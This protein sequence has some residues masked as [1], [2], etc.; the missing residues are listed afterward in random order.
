MASAKRFVNQVV[1]VGILDRIDGTVAV[2][3]DFDVMSTRRVTLQEDDDDYTGRFQ[4]ADRSLL[5]ETKESMRHLIE[6]AKCAHVHARV[7]K[8][9]I[10]R[11]LSQRVTVEGHTARRGALTDLPSDA[12]GNTLRRLIALTRVLTVSLRTLPHMP[13]KTVCEKRIECAFDDLKLPH[14]LREQ[15]CEEVSLPLGSTP[16]MW[17]LPLKHVHRVQKLH[18]MNRH[19]PL[20]LFATL[21]MQRVY[22]REEMLQSTLESLDAALPSDTVPFD[23]VDATKNAV[24]FGV[25]DQLTQSSVS[26]L[27]SLEGPLRRAVQSLK[28]QRRLQFLDVLV[29]H[30]TMPTNTT[31]SARWSALPLRPLAEQAEWHLRRLQGVLQ[32]ALLPA[33]L[34][35]AD[36]HQPWTTFLLEQLALCVALADHSADFADTARRLAAQLLRR[37]RLQ[38]HLHA[39][40][41]QELASQC[42]GEE[43]VRRLRHHDSQVDTEDLL[44]RCQ[45][46]CR[47]MERQSIDQAGFLIDTEGFL[48]TLA[49]VPEVPP[50]VWKELITCGT[51]MCLAKPSLAPRL[52]EVLLL[53]L[54]RHCDTPRDALALWHFV[55][56]Y[57][58]SG[59]ISPEFTSHLAQQLTSA[60]ARATL[61]VWAGAVEYAHSLN[62]QDKDSEGD[63]ETDRPGSAWWIRVIQTHLRA[64][65]LQDISATATKQVARSILEDTGEVERPEDDVRVSVATALAL[66]PENSM[67]GRHQADRHPVD[68]VAFLQ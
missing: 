62:Q 40:L 37:P 32:D 25:R 14:H 53:P 49:K 65:Q 31:T 18:K 21:P 50:S 58:R 57:D 6:D 43:H 68:L 7:L 51:R 3:D 60:E 11:V 8:Q 59:Y 16:P 66:S 52:H 39:E 9:R 13:T 12:T 4:E 36:R 55:H 27:V 10:E 30:T 42:L 26:L 41:I 28:Q 2:S 63:Q 54:L 29:E 45:D 47:A 38:Q 24:G 33:L 48:K 5:F 22:E 64:L 19:L 15:L 61:G 20:K 46:V 56:F 1:S 23:A 35:T 44:T 67:F 34:A 17:H